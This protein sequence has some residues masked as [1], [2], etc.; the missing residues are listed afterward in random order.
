VAEQVSATFSALSIPSRDISFLADSGVLR[1]AVENRLDDGIRNATLELS[2]E[3]PIL[4]IESGP[5]PVEVGAGSR[6]TVG[7]DAT[8]I[9]SGQVLVTAVVRAPDG[10]T[11]GDPSSFTVRVSPTAEWI[12]WVLGA[13]AVLVILVGIA[14]TVLRRRR[15]VTTA[16]PT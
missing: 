15:T 5:Q 11:L 12:Y 7:F 16:A 3:H 1:V 13:L 9:A 4:R 6:T 14:R 2:V 10:T 8:A